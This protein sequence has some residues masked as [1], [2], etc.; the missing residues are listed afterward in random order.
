MATS[1]FLTTQ[2]TSDQ[3]VESCGAILFDF[4]VPEKKVCLLYYIEKDEWLLPKG[5]RNCRESRQEAALR[6]VSEETGYPCHLHPITMSTRA[7]PRDEAGDAA[8]EAR[9]LPNLT[10]SFMM[11]TRLLGESNVK[12]IWWY[13]ARLDKDAPT[14]KFVGEAEFKAEFLSCAEALDKLSFGKDKTILQRAIEL[15]E[16]TN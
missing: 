1:N 4:D 3:Y 13:I 6:E 14:K 5:R 16:R 11:E 10:E 2:Y 9:S 7:P 12:L 15:V 8:D